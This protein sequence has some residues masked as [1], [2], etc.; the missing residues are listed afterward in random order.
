MAA[1][2]VLYVGTP[3]IVGLCAAVMAL[4]KAKESRDT[5][6]RESD[7][8]NVQVLTNLTKMFEIMHVDISKLPL[9]VSKE[10]SV[11]LHEIRSSL[12]IQKK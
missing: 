8:A 11:I 4:W 12:S 5:Y 3:M 10:L 6:I 7:K 9:E 1:K 2:I